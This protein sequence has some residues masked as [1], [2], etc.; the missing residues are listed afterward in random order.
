[1]KDNRIFKLC[2]TLLLLLMFTSC[3]NSTL[4]HEE[5]TFDRNIWNRFVGETFEFDV[6]NVEDYYH[7]DITVAVDT[8]VYR[9]TEFPL[10]VEMHG[11]N[12]ETRQFYTTVALTDRGAP[13]G[14]VR[15]GYRYVKGRIR[16]YFSFNNKGHYSM[17]LTH[18]TSQYDLEGIHSVAVDITRA[19]LDYDEF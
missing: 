14:E 19:K 10:S 12:G 15:D 7:L 9:Y 18:T 2:T 3:S 8:A 5:H 13:R 4:Y 1:M 6:K 16:S 17:E 11:A